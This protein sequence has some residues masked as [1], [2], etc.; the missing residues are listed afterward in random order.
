MGAISF[1]GNVIIALIP[2]YLPRGRWRALKSPLS[3][4]LFLLAPCLSVI[5]GRFEKNVL[6]LASTQWI[7]S[8]VCLYNGAL[9]FA[10][11]GG[12]AEKLSTRFVSE[13]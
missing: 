11:V 2:I 6:P 4:F 9:R 3:L 1:A 13:Y 8:T 7:C 5:M 12:N 10:A